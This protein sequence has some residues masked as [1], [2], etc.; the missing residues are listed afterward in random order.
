M[1]QCK[2][3][4]QYI[5]KTKGDSV[6]CK[7][8]CGNYFH[9]TC[10]GNIK[11]FALNDTCEEC[12]KTPKQ[13]PKTVPK[14]DLDPSKLTVENLLT[15]VNKK[16]EVIYTMKK[17]LDEMAETI[18]FYAEK[19]QELIDFKADCIE[20][21]KKTENKITDLVNRNKYLEK[22][23]SALEERV[24][25]IEQKETEKKV[26]LVGVQIQ[27]D[28]IRETVSQI[29]SKLELPIQ[30][31]VD[32]W[33]VGGEKGK[34]DRRNTTLIMSLRTK[35]ARDSW[36]QRRKQRLTNNFFFKNAT[37]DPIY[38]NENITKQTRNLFWQTKTN[39]KT[40]HKFIWIQNSKI[41]VK[42][43][44]DSKIINIR[45]EADIQAQMKD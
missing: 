12:S 35:S 9:K 10:A 40:S 39:L 25:W 19:Y 38:I 17:Q 26:E 31:I 22:C 2:K 34:T 11:T 8:L 20:K 3:C 7:G 23:N 43:D 27:N 14:I 4:K 28:S 30:D 37:E 16:M 36:L 42:K 5:S 1:V 13:S 24:Q 41:L 29:A 21:N 15:E 32:V 45:Q 33:R 44:A 6:Q 18:D